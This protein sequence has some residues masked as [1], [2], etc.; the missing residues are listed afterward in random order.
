MW[1]CSCY[2]DFCFWRGWS[3][4]NKQFW[5]KVLGW[6]WKVWSILKSQPKSSK[7]YSH[8]FK[9]VTL[10]LKALDIKTPLTSRKVR[11]WSWSL[12]IFTLCLKNSS[13]KVKNQNLDRKTSP[14]LIFK[15]VTLVSKSHKMPFFVATPHKIV[16]RSEIR[17]LN[18]FSQ[19]IP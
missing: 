7:K 14:I 2:H 1:S 9:R 17:A 10:I 5:S 3:F 4:E 16:S 6:S 13:V 8:I 19:K 12:K 15:N 11:P 18:L